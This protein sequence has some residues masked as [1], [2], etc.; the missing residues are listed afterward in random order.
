MNTTTVYTCSYFCIIVALCY[1][2]FIL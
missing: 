1:L 2:Q